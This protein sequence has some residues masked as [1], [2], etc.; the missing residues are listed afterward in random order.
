MENGNRAKK[1]VFVLVGLVIFV[2]SLILVIK[3]AG[4]IY[5]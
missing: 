1:E 4:N 2:V 5:G 3:E